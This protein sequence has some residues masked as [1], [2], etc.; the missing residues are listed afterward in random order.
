[1]CVLCMCKFKIFKFSSADWDLEKVC[2]GDTRKKHV[3]HVL[4]LLYAF[5]LSLS[6]SVG[7]WEFQTRHGQFFYYYF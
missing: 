3:Q 5:F 7:A 6:I 2:E 1:M 4:G